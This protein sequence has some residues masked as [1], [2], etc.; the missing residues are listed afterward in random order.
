MGDD[1]LRERRT[2]RSDNIFVVY[3]LPG[4]GDVLPEL[5]GF[6]VQ[7]L[8]PVSQRRRLGRFVSLQFSSSLN[9]PPTLRRTITTAATLRSVF[10]LHHGSYRGA[11]HY[12][13]FAASQ[14][15]LTG[16]VTSQS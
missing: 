2:R 9:A 1:F 15:T 10:Q 13:R 16:L 3:T 7:Q 11:E 12:P 6:D 8:R 14:K 5:Y 4:D